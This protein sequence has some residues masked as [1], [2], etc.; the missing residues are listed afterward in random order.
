M[1]ESEKKMLIAD[2]I[3]C[4]QKSMYEEA[5]NIV[6]SLLENCINHTNNLYISMDLAHLLCLAGKYNEALP[7]LELLVENV[8]SS[9]NPD[10]MV[11]EKLYLA[12][13]CCLYN[14]KDFIRFLYFINKYLCL[15]KESNPEAYSTIKQLLF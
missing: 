15:A 9:S 4:Y 5:A 13:A 10:L 11:L 12:Y 6:K 14:E 2:I 7:M 1:I 3:S 8:E